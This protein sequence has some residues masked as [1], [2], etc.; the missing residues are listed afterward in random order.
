MPREWRQAREFLEHRLEGSE[1]GRVLHLQA[2]LH[3]VT[4][5]VLP[6][7]RSLR[8]TC[9]QG[10]PEFVPGCKPE[11]HN[12]KYQR[13]CPPPRT[14]SQRQQEGRPTRHVHRQQATNKDARPWIPTTR[15]STLAAS[16]LA[17]PRR[18]GSHI[19]SQTMRLPRSSFNL[20]F[21]WGLGLGLRSRLRPR[22]WLGLAYA[23]SPPFGYDLHSACRYGCGLAHGS[24]S[25]TLLAPLRLRPPF[26]LPLRLRPCLRFRLRFRRRLR[27]PHPLA[28]R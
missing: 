24:G 25:R 12:R 18:R 1:P 17:G 11:S 19:L 14:R 22:S 10:V 20:G 6:S 28:L 15:S 26:R 5:D 7:R 3:I 4:R 27:W 8:G 21:G 9:T 13:W 2:Q 16:V 23:S